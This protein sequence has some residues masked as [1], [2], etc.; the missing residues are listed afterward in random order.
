MKDSIKPFIV[1]IGLLVLWH[2]LV[3]TFDMPAYILPGP[4][5][6]AKQHG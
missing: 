2:A 3:I 6:V 5:E 1:L 4:L